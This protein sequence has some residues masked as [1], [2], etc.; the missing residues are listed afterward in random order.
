MRLCWF[1]RIF[2]VECFGDFGCY[3]MVIEE[4]DIWDREYWIVVSCYWCFKVFNKVLM[5]GWLY[6]YLVILV[7]FYVF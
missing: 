2:W 6:Y 4:D 1:L 7:C 3:R 5:I